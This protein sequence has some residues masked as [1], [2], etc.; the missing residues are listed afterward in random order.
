MTYE[1]AQTLILRA[2]ENPLQPVSAH[3]LVQAI[4]IVLVQNGL[5]G[6]VAPTEG[7]G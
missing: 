5:L 4:A 1:E 3:D 2:V 6:F 7:E